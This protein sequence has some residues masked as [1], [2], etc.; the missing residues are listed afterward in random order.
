MRTNCHC[1]SNK[2]IEQLDKKMSMNLVDVKS[3]AHKLKQK[4]ENPKNVNE[5]VK[6]QIKNVESK[7]AKLEREAKKIKQ[8][9]HNAAVSLRNKSDKTKGSW[10][11]KRLGGKS[12]K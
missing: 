11:G 10:G 2:S 12:C 4:V 5:N 3:I 6:K 9:C 8:H 7:S 1:R